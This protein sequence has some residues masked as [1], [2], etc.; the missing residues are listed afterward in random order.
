MLLKD[1]TRVDKLQMVIVQR[2]EK[3]LSSKEW[4]NKSQDNDQKYDLII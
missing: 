3:D 4:I 2:K 1:L